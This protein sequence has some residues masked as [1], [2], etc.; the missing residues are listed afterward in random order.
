VNLN[1]LIRIAKVTSAI[2]VV[3]MTAYGI[4]GCS[5]AGAIDTDQESYS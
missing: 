1:F 4:A 5:D 2:A 3:G